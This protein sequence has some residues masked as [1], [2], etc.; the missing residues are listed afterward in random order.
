MFLMNL[1]LPISFYVIEKRYSVSPPEEINNLRGFRTSASMQ[2]PEA[3]L[4]VQK[5]MGKIMKKASVPLGII[6]ALLMLYP[7][8]KSDNF[9]SF[10]GGVIVFLQILI[11]FVLI[12][13]INKTVK[14]KFSK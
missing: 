12:I 8:G 4:F 3:W 11:M 10:Y 9:V 1:I 6:S 2:S 5:Y 13:K 7:I 14:E